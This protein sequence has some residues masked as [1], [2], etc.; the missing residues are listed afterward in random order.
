MASEDDDIEDFDDDWESAHHAGPHFPV[1]LRE[2]VDLLNIHP[3]K[4]YVDATAGAG[5]HLCEIAKL[6]G[7]ESRVFGFDRDSEAIENLRDVVP[8]NVKLIHSNY[9]F[10]RER[11]SQEGVNTVDGGILADLGVSSMQ[12]DDAQRGF[13][14]LRDG[15]LDMRMDPTQSTTA[16]YLVNTLPERDLADIIYKFGEERHSKK[17]AK[18]IVQNRP[19][20]ST[21]KLADVVSRTLNKFQ[22]R[23][24]KRSSPYGRGFQVTK[25]PATRTFQA[26]RIAVNTELES[27][28]NFLQEAVSLLAPDARLVVISFHSLEDRIVKQFLKSKAS[29]CVCPP[30]QPLCTCNKKSELLIITRKPVVADEQE[31]L[32]NIRSRSAKLRAGQKLH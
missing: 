25:H 28:E 29:P 19:F 16:A 30:R 5:G 14:F 1:M 13:S 3:G 24:R 12:I 23:S 4:I 15:P 18:M 2:A 11:L 10:L 6:A 26:L 31:L 8:N 9:S 7:P 20:E 32:A 17:I 27:L 22:N 21:A